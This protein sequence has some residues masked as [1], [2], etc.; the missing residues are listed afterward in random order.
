MPTGTPLGKEFIIVNNAGDLNSQVSIDTQATTGSIQ[1]SAGS[2]TTV[3]H[4]GGDQFAALH[5][6]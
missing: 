6:F 1:L 3:I 5:S 2:A 4:I